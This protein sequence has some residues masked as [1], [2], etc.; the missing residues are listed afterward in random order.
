MLQRAALTILLLT[1]CAI[2]LTLVVQ[3]R[4][5]PATPALPSM[6]ASTSTTAAPP[7]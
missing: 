7:T 6:M 4:Q 2:C 3:R 5:T 1:G